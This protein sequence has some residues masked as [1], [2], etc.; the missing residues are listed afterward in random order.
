M[1]IIHYKTSKRIHK[2]IKKLTKRRKTKHKSNKNPESLINYLIKRTRFQYGGEGAQPVAF[3]LSY[4]NSLVLQ[5]IRDSSQN[6]PN[7]S[8]VDTNLLVINPTVTVPPGY[9]G[10]LIMYDPDAPNPAANPH[11]FIHWMVKYDG[12]GNSTQL[13][14]Y[15][16][17][18]P[19]LGTHRY[20]FIFLENNSKILSAA[21]AQFKKSRLTNTTDIKNIIDNNKIV[22][23]FGYTVASK[24]ISF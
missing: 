19:P 2:T 1:A 11:I 17:P 22:A 18:S 16:Q 14:D 8:N 7:L 6:L 4:G 23:I 24:S 5:Q 3:G 21:I 10:H 13:I 20:F 12:S 15:T 9:S